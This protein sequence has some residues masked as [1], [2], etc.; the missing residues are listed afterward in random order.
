VVNTAADVPHPGLAGDT[1][2]LHVCLHLSLQVL[3]A[4]GN[5]LSTLPDGFGALTGLIRLGL[6]GNQLAALPDSFTG[7]TN[8]VELFLTDNKL[9]TLPQGEPAGAAC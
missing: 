9:T 6:K 5:E 7:L 8:L 4:W 3:N 1:S 2:K